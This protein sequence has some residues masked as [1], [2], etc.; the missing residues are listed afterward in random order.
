LLC[1]LFYFAF[2]GDFVNSDIVSITQQKMQH[3]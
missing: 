2:N 1:D 3:E